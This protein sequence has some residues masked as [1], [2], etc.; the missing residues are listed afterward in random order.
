MAYRDRYDLEPLR[1]RAWLRTGVI[2][3]RWLPLDGVLLYQAHR[4]M[5]GPQVVTIPGDYSCQGASTLPLAIEH[6]GRRNWYYRCSWAQWSHQVEGTDHWN[7]R[8]DSSLADLVDFRGRRGKVIV[9]EGQFKAYH[10]PVFYRAALWIEWYC[11][12]DRTEIESLLCTLTHLG[13]KGVQG[14]G[15]V[16][17]WEIEPCMEDWSVW[18]EGK[19]MRGIPGED[20]PEHMPVNLAHYGIRPS[21]WKSENQTMLAVPE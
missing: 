20:V 7:K 3:D 21:Y 6:P 1:I 5:M 10:M 11:I 9:G 13:K 15:R 17:R 2:A 19:L 14:W 4:D 12:G 8:F 16:I 18:R